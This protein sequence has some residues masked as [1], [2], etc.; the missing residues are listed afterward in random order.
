ME[1]GGVTVVAAVVVA[2]VVEAEEQGLLMITTKL[3][4]M[5]QDGDAVLDCDRR[6]SRWNR[7]GSSTCLSM[8]SGYVARFSRISMKISARLHRYDY[9]IYDTRL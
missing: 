4:K 5:G 6:R 8:I 2:V 1:A 7:T 3:R 9:T